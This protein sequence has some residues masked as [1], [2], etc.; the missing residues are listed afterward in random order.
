MSKTILPALTDINVPQH[1]EI[2][3]AA[4]IDELYAEAGKRSMMGYAGNVFFGT[5]FVQGSRLQF[6]TAMP[7]VKMVEVS[8]IDRSIE[9]E[10]LSTRGHGTRE[11][12]AGGLPRKGS[13][14]L[15]VEHGVHRRQV[16]LACVH[17]Q[18]RSWSRS[19]FSGCDV[20]LVRRGDGGLDHMARRALSAA[21]GDSRHNGRRPSPVADRGDLD[22]L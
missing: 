20:D 16:H 18:L 17:I 7:V 4:N 1:I 15:F 10:G 21:R 3:N 8:K 19:R 2:V 13:P 9:E 12:A 5:A 11:P 6:T 22:Q 14:G